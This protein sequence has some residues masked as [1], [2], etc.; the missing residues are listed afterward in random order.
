MNPDDCINY[1]SRAESFRP[2]AKNQGSP[3]FLLRASVVI[4]TGH[5]VE[6]DGTLEHLQ[7]ALPRISEG[8]GT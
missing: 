2:A 1:F 7:A 5:T 6:I 4:A 3:N 8:V